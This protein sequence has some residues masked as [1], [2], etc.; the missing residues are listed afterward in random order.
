MSDFSNQVVCITGAGSGIGQQSALRFAEAGASIVAADLNT[1]GLQETVRLVAEAGAAIETVTADTSDPEQVKALVDKCLSAF[2]GLDV[3]FA[4]AGVAGPI[5]PL[6]QNADK[7]IARVIEVNIL[8]PLYAVKYAGPVMA[9]RGKGAIV[10]TA[11]VAGIAANAGPVTYSASKAAVISLAKTAAQELA[12]SGVR[13]NAICPGLT[14]TGMTKPIFDHAE[15][16]NSTHKLGQLNP[17]RRAGNTDDIANNVLF[18]ASDKAAYVNGHAL[19]I[20]GG[21]STS[22]PYVPAYGLVMT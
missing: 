3:F 16:N 19:V 22:M 2:G 7:D 1:E 6:N 4:N 15:K 10:L 21:L 14:E 20:D 5:A 17:S 9:T 18:L 11:S 13:V 12:G 8:G